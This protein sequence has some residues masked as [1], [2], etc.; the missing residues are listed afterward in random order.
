MRNESAH[1][2]SLPYVTLHSSLCLL[3]SP[4]WDFLRAGLPQRLFPHTS[5]NFDWVLPL[6][7]SAVRAPGSVP[8]QSHDQ[9]K[10]LFPKSFFCC[11]GE[12][13]YPSFAEIFQQNHMF[14]NLQTPKLF[15][16]CFSSW[17]KNGANWKTWGMS[18]VLGG[19][20]QYLF[21]SGMWPLH[22]KGSARKDSSI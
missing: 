17:N 1:R 5:R 15:W 7:L 22:Q 13:M 2:V 3:C 8:A 12:S 16:L 14:S 18:H 19:R 20:V 10:A 6:P 9:G 11:H 21:L 4:T